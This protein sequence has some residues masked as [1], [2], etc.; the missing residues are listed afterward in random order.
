MATE[1]I[2]IGEF[3][4]L[5]DILNAVAKLR[6]KGIENFDVYS[7]FPNHELEDEV[8]KYRPRSPVRRVTLVGA[9]SGCL[10]AFLMTSWM[11]MDWPLRTSAKPILSFPAFV[12]IGFECT[13]LIGAIFTLLAMFHF[14]RIP[15]FF[16]KPG[17]RPSFSNGTFGL[18]A[19]VNKDNSGLVEQELKGCGAERVEVEYVR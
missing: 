7:P 12:V 5:D 18:V 6:E 17:F 10:G 3:K 2:V 19:R 9:V 14:S 13:I 4:Y 15:N 16:P 1:N 11:S 8:Y